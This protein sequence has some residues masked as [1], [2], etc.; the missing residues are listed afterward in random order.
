MKILYITYTGLLYACM[1]DGLPYSDVSG[2][3]TSY[4]AT[5]ACIRSPSEQTFSALQRACWQPWRRQNASWEA[6]VAVPAAGAGAGAGAAAVAG[7]D[8]AAGPEMAFAPPRAPPRPLPRGTNPP[9]PP[10]AGPVGGP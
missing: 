7:L 6:H 1:V 9:R 8:A 2:C 5:R 4:P 10:R 3:E